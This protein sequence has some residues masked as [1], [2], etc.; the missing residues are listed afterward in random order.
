MPPLFVCSSVTILLA[1]GC[2]RGCTRQLTRQSSI[3]N[4]HPCK[5]NEPQELRSVRRIYCVGG[6]QSKRQMIDRRLTP[7]VAWLSVKLLFNS[8]L[9]NPNLRRRNRTEINW[10]RSFVFEIDRWL[11]QWIDPAFLPQQLVFCF[12]SAGLLSSMFSF[13]S[14]LMV[15][16]FDFGFCFSFPKAFSVCPPRLRGSVVRFGFGFVVAVPMPCDLWPV[17]FG[18]RV[19]PSTPHS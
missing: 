13:S 17:P 19:Y 4:S 2:Q 1:T 3:A 12:F 5:S 14:V 11:L 8:S 18:S 15:F 9:L 7:S 16:G 6:K 10:S